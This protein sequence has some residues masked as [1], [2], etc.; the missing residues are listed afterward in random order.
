MR[1]KSRLSSTPIV[2][3]PRRSM[4]VPVALMGCL[5]VSGCSAGTGDPSG[6]GGVDPAAFVDQ[7]KVAIEQAEA[8]G[9]SD[10]QLSILREAQVEGVLTFE[11]ALSAALST[12]DCYIEGGGSG[13]YYENVEDSGLVVPMY[14]AL[15]KDDETLTRLEPMM[16]ACGKREGFWVNKVYQLQ[17]SSQETRDAYLKEQA[18]VIRKC[19]EDHGHATD[20]LATPEE[21][22]QQAMEVD[23]DTNGA[24]NCYK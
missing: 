1:L 14:M 11:Q 2:D 10:D 9:A 17:P 20:R 4:R 12:L 8:G 15:A 3:P 13:T 22:V 19:L 6:N 23:F 21:L 18:P 7:V 5:V 24:I 16:D